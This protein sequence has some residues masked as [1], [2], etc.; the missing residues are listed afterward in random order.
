M[1]GNI[2]GLFA[3]GK[4]FITDHNIPISN[5]LGNA[6]EIPSCTPQSNNRIMV[7]TTRSFYLRKYH[8]QAGTIGKVVD[9]VCDGRLLLVDFDLA[10]V[11]R[12]P[13]GS[14]LIEAVH[15]ES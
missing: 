8:V 4:E 6:G 13:A 5:K 15:R 12:I 3:N 7:K 2:N 11:A 10:V 9:L 14:D 1:N